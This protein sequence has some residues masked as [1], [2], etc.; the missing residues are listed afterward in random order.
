MSRSVSDAPT[1]WREG[2]RLR[3]WELF[4]QGWPQRQIAQ[5]LGVSEGAV[6]QWLTE[7]RH[8]GTTA[9]HSR[10]HPGPQPRLSPEQQARVRALLRQGAVAL[11]FHGERWTQQR[12][13][14][15][16]RRE[17]GVIYSPSHIS[18]LLDQWHFSSQKPIRRARQR[19][20]AAIRQWRE[21]RYPA[22]AKR[23]RE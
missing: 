23:G 4:Q 5:A 8:A 18:R 6:S 17:F 2:R 16:I 3:A 9:L 1:T 13:R 22:L 11:G 14:E 7:A 12:V 20:E 19:D 15:L 10:P 21:K